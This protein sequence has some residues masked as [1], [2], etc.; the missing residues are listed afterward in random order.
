MRLSRIRRRLSRVEEYLPFRLRPNDSTLAFTDWLNVT[1]EIS[2]PQ[3]QISS[4]FSVTAS[5]MP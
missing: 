3:G 1:M 2:T 5:W 4:R